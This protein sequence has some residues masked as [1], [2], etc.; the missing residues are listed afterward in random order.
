MENKNKFENQISDSLILAFFLSLTGGFQDAYSYY[1]RDKVFANAQTGNIVLMGGHIFSGEFR[2]AVHYIFPVLAFVGGIYITEWIRYFFKDNHKIHWR[3]IIL[4]VQ[5]I[6]MVI[7]GFMPETLNVPANV[8]LSF[9][10]AVQITTFKKFRGVPFATTMC[11]GN[12]RNATEFLAKYHI[13]KDREAKYKSSYYYGAILVFA[14]GASLGA[15]ASK[16]LHLKA[17]WIAAVFLFLGFILMMIKRDFKN[18]ENDIRKA[19]KNIISDFIE[20]ITFLKN[21]FRK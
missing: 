11:I 20:E 1:C 9:S 4:F 3:Q 12:M 19:E 8:L 5:I 21:I 13:S 15:V 14:L 7:V 2:E 18:I 16:Y 17:I 6:L 10:C